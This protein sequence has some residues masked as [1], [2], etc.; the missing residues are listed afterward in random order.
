MRALTISMRAIQKCIFRLLLGTI[1]NLWCFFTFMSGGDDNAF[2]SLTAQFSLF[3]SLN[4]S[5]RGDKE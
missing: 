3:R 2:T 5:V 4:F 1:K